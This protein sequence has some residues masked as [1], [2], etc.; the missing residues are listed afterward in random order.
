MVDETDVNLEDD[1]Q[2]LIDEPYSFENM[3][4]NPIIKPIAETDRSIRDI[5][6]MINK[7]LIDTK[8][9]Q[10]WVNAAM[11]DVP[12]YQD[13]SFVSRLI[14]LSQETQDVIKLQDLQT[15]NLRGCIKEIVA[16]VYDKYGVKVEEFGEEESYVEPATNVPAG[17]Y[18]KYLISL[19][20]STVPSVKDMAEKI[21]KTY[22][23][24]KKSKTDK[25][26]F[27]RACNI[28]HKE[29]SDK[30]KKSAAQKIIRMEIGGK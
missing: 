6:E 30:E 3:V 14:K 11:S 18:E 1:V 25:E 29:E 27:N 19:S 20:E 22:K 12:A 5:E 23:A 24:D 10:D 17:D 7:K 15:K 13:S 21:L 8:R 28:N 16:I 2:P 26:R 4:Q 9:D